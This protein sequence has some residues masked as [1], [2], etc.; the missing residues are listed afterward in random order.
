MPSDGRFAPLIDK[1]GVSGS[2]VAMRMLKLTYWSV[3]HKV[4][5]SM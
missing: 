1:L 2:G 5:N 4:E 3:I